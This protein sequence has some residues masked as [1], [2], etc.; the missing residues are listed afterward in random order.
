LAGKVFAR[1]AAADDDYRLPAGHIVV[2]EGS[3]FEYRNAQG[4]KIARGDVSRFE[5][6]LLVVRIPR[7][8]HRAEGFAAAERQKIGSRGSFHAG[9]SGYPADQIVEECIPALGP[10]IPAIQLDAGARGRCRAKSLVNTL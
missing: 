3:A 1:K 5:E 4:C 2:G 9:R 6:G 10:L 7:Y 8:F